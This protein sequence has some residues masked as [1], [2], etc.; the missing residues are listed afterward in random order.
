MT[1]NKQSWVAFFLG[2]VVSVVV[3]YLLT[4]GYRRLG[5]SCRTEIDNIGREVNLFTNG[6]VRTL[7]GGANVGGANDS[8][9]KV[10]FFYTNWCGYSRQF[11]PVWDKLVENQNPQLNHVSFEK[12]DCDQDSNELAKMYDVKGFPTVVW[13]GNGEI[14]HYNGD[15]NAKSIEEWVLDKL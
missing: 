11:Q 8:Q 2:V 6:I 5:K 1:P 9:P 12:I 13:V 3:G 4:S 14:Q 7:V 15:R 10:L